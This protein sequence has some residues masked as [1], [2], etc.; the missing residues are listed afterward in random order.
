MSTITQRGLAPARSVLD[1][2]AVVIAKHA[3]ATPAVTIHASFD[4]GTVYDPPAQPGV[5][6]FV[7]RTIDRGTLT[8]SADDIAEHLDSR[9]ISLTTSVN[10]HALS[11]MCTCLVEDLDTTLQ[12]LADVV[13]HPTFPDT[14]VETRRV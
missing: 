5:G 13:M 11:L 14:E 4:A 6:H 2:G 10:R 1:N 8:R 7:S 3:S 12:I 9:G